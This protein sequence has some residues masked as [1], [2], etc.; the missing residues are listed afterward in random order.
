MTLR[1][2]YNV[3]LG[4]IA[5]DHCLTQ[6]AHAIAGVINVPPIWPLAYGGEEFALYFAQHSL[7]GGAVSPD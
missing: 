1:G 3:A 6:V 2:L 4:H 7:R 5:G